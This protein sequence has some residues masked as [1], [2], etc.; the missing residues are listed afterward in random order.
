[1]SKGVGIK[2]G[3]IDWNFGISEHSDI[4]TD[5]LDFT[6]SSNN[7]LSGHG[8]WMAAVLKEIAPECEVYGLGV[9]TSPYDES[10]KV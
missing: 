5:V 10:R 8:Y 1:M 9:G 6:G 2:V 7:H 4:Y 3:I